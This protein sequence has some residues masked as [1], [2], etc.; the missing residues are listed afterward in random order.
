MPGFPCTD[1]G[2][3][4]RKAVSL[5]YMPTRDGVH[6]LHQV[7][8]DG[9]RSSCSIYDIRPPLCRVDDGILPRDTDLQ[10]WHQRNAVECDKMQEAEGLGEEWRVGAVGIEPTTSGS[11]GQRSTVTTSEDEPPAAS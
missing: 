8:D 10:T 6:C 11:V 3:C 5:G 7:V 4:C 9:G 1:C 2:A